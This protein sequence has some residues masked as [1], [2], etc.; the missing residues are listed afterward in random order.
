MDG[1]VCVRKLMLLSLLMAG[2]EAEK[3]VMDPMG[4]SEGRREVV[5]E[6]G[7]WKDEDGDKECCVS[8]KMVGVDGVEEDL[9]GGRVA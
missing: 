4:V 2:S 3:N 8:V 1:G 9:V 7:R 5:G 6:T